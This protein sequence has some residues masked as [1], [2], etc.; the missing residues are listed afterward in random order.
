M[1]ST[2]IAMEAKSASGDES[3][4]MLG[5]RLGLLEVFAGG[6]GGPA[7]LETTVRAVLGAV[8]G[9]GGVLGVRM[10]LITFGGLF[11]AAR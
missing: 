9:D 6:E 5:K 3:V 1:L 11:D 7:D 4:R 10:V 2:E 8:W